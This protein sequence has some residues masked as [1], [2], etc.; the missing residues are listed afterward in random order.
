MDYRILG[1]LGVCDG[2]REVSLGGDKQRALLAA[3]LVHANEVVSADQLIDDLWGEHP[4]PTALKT[5]QAYV[6]RL[7]KALGDAEEL[8]RRSP[9]GR[10]V[11]QRHGYVLFVKPGELDVDRFR[12]RAEHGRAAL[13]AGEAEEAA[14]LLREALA[15]WRGPPLS[16]FAY[17]AFAAP[18]IAQL[19]ELR[20]AALEERCEADLALGRDH[21]LVGELSG[22]V[23]RNPLRER[24][25]AQ[26]MIALYHCGRQAEALDVYQE[27]RQA[28]SEELG[29][30]PSSRLA[31]L[32]LAILNRD[33]SLEPAAIHQAQARPRT[34][35]PAPADGRAR[36]VRL[37]VGGLAGAAV[38]VAAAVLL[39]SGGERRQIS[40]V[41]AN[42]V[43]AISPTS[44][45]ID[46][47][48][49]VGS[50]PSRL[51][52]GYRSLWVTNSNA[53]TVTRIDLATQTVRQTVP[54][55]SQPGGIAV[56][57]GAVWVTD[58]LK[59]T[60]SRIDPT[61]GR[62]VQ[63]I[64]VGNG[65]SGVAVGNG[66]VWVTNSSDATLSRVDARTG[67]VA[68]TI[69]LGGG[70][71]DAAVGMG[72]VWVS[73]EAAGRV[74]RV[75]TQTDQVTASIRVGTG[76]GAIAVGDGSV[77]VTNGL[78]GTVS[79]IDPKT[80]SVTATIAVGDGPDAIAVGAR[81]VWVA[82]EFG[83]TVVRLDPS[84]GAVAR[85]LRVGNPVSGISV[86]GATVWV[87]ARATGDRHRGGT[88]RVLSHSPL[89]SF[90][91]AQA[92]NFGGYTHL[93]NDG[94]T[95]L[96]RVGGGDGAQVV[97]DLAVSLPTPTDG[98]LTYTF[99]LRRG[100]RYSNGTVVRPED[101]RRAIERDFRL[102]DANAQ[103]YY[104]D[105]AGGSACT[106]HPTRCTLSRGITTDDVA[107]TVTFHL[108][109]PDPELLDRLAV[110]D[111][112][113]VPASAPS[114]DVGIHPLPATGPYAVNRASSRQVVFTRNP[115]FHEWS[116]AARPDGYPDQIVLK[117]GASP[118][119][120]LTAVERGRADYSLDDPPPQ[121]LNEL[122]TR[123][124]SQLHVNPDVVLNEL[125]LNTRVS[126][127]NDIRVRR[128][129]NYAVD[130]A[131]V[132][133]LT[134]SAA[135]PT[136]QFLTPFIPGY[137]RYCP[138]TL[139]PGSGGPW[140]APDINR[141]RDL[142]AA[143]GTKGTGITIWNLGILGDATKVA[144]YLASL[145]R[146]LGYPTRVRTLLSNPNAAAQFANSKDRA[147]VA[148]IAYFPN[149]PAASEYI[150]WFL[151]CKNFV[152]NSAS[153]ANW[154]EFCDRTLDAK[155]D[156]A[157]TAQGA[158]SPAAVGLWARAD[159]SATDLAPMVPLAVPDQLDVVSRRVGNFQY[160]PQLGVLP[161]Q[162][163]V[164]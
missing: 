30:E 132:A 151:S 34:V 124:A 96:K 18:A 123:F 69:S 82:N 21:E 130:R 144:Q 117:F 84:S 135:Q 33:P 20:L 99:Q 107:N 112:V 120:E 119:A 97:P 148:L 31:S 108:T 146:Q 86:A 162:L 41:A 52:A 164:R 37:A 74:L 103:A 109:A 158:D 156:R 113:A 137:R 22:L 40:A 70:A 133:R 89:G 72:A 61:V 154:P 12:E 131:E 143:S 138:Y 56:G 104:A 76:P 42:S 101:F 46:S 63:T 94:L 110:W 78:D 126:P 38:A 98:G 58:A 140:R 163:W 45:A 29:L 50:S 125:V 65:P 129:L 121:R 152:P 8:G 75:D 71:T 79:R 116:H 83:G 7:R 139:R 161:D 64:A 19:E 118:S 35:A 155:I 5:L 26:L 134:G 15:L 102:G 28:L 51:A 153:N 91:P 88:L 87:G 141:A 67:S 48:V 32:E 145:L 57:A 27:F 10:L 111:A 47:E 54:L 80:N 106:I 127:F 93:T 157:L 6:S 150:K 49:L 53:D 4:P 77:W 39:T 92:Y 14:R 11:T 44:G 16:E 24:L 100:I 90:D 68:R 115:Y 149:Y 17:E 1:P 59:G 85:T 73:D 55:S 122:Y 95:A 23:Q 142:I 25:R 81:G 128:A 3:L 13:A 105:L 66:A 62:V 136:C 159:R 147:Q 9:T 2:D 160:N 36:R 60:V 43:G 114:R